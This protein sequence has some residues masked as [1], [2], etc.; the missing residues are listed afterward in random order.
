MLNYDVLSDFDFEVLSK[1]ILSRILGINLFYFAKGPDQGID[2]A[3]K[4][5][6]P[7][8]VV[9]VKHYSKSTFAQLKSSLKKE[10]AKID[11]IQLETY[12][13]VTSQSLTRQ[14]I[15]EIYLDF[16]DY[17]SS[18]NCIFTKETLDSFLLHKDNSDILRKHFK[19]W[20]T[21]D[22]VLSEISNRDIFID[23][24]SLLDD[25][26]DELPYFV[27]TEVF[28]KALNILQEHKKILLYGD[29]GVGKTITSKM[30]V[31]NF[32]KQGYTVRYTT[33]GSIANLKRSL[34]ND[35]EKN[36]IVFLDD[37]LGQH[38][39]NLQ[40]NQENE[41][42]SLIRY[43]D[44]NPNKMLILNS[45]ITILN[46]AIQNFS[47]LEKY[48]VFKDFKMYRIDLSI[49]SDTEKAR[50]FLAKLKQFRV[51]N[52]YYNDVRKNNGYRTIIKHKNYNPRLIEFVCTPKRYDLV[53]TECYCN[54]I[55]DNLQNPYAVW[56]NEFVNRLEHI[57]RIFMYI[58][59]SIT[60][61]KV[62]IEKLKQAFNFYIRG[63]TEETLNYFDSI[64][65]LLN[66]SL[67]KIDVYQGQRRVGVINP[68]VNDF[69]KSSIESNINLKIKLL[70]HAIF[71]DQ[72]ARLMTKDAFKEKLKSIIWDDNN[73]DPY[74]GLVD[75]QS[76]DLY[77]HLIAEHKVD[78]E[79]HLHLVF[80]LLFDGLRD[81]HIG[82]LYFSAFKTITIFLEDNLLWSHY[83]LKSYHFD[84]D[85]INRIFYE[86]RDIE[87]AVTVVN[88]LMKRLKKSYENYNDLKFIL[89]KELQSKIEL[90]IDDYDFAELIANYNLQEIS[91][92][93]KEIYNKF[94]QHIDIELLKIENEDIKS[95]YDVE[96]FLSAKEFSQIFL[97]IV[98]DLTNKNEH[99]NEMTENTDYSIDYIL[100]RSI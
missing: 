91:D 26:E 10:L 37:F 97:E 59:Y 56:E 23:C 28:F 9:Q 57:D 1:D 62:D 6:N 89:Q 2:L 4:I 52:E 46:Q 60:D 7:S 16:Q 81:V 96:E 55:L 40:I 34:S 21:A 49:I 14:R 15:E 67:L 86:C 8:I 82:K 18:P 45:R 66:E 50:I 65:E 88:L 70:E 72:L 35:A 68:S 69:L 17:M 29:P 99:H 30:L 94:K 74:I 77:I 58:L 13:I 47:V 48:F 53:S 71:Y 42:L 63:S 25:I 39:M 80:D 98:E 19:L 73:C 78:S 76:V 51:P 87:D 22:L 31:L 90:H 85:V 93:E 38:Y 33:N 43:I 36:E 92:Y 83:D 11:K 75:N 3:D 20:L 100:D 12:Y 27:E 41:L 5:I 54:F 61:Y 24:E 79:S 84:E 32:I 95:N 64:L 44:R